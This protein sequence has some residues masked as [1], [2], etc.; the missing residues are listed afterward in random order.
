MQ[1]DALGKN[2]LL[3]KLQ[4]NAE[5]QYLCSVRIG[6]IQENVVTYLIITVPFYI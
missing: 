2:F 3:R 1:D 6:V 4:V 5:Y